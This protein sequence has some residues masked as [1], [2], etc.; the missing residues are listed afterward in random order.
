MDS[1]G[2]IRAHEDPID[3]DPIRN[4]RSVNRPHARLVRRKSTL[5]KNGIR[6]SEKKGVSETETPKHCLGYF[7]DIV[8]GGK[9]A[10]QLYSPPAQLNARNS[11]GWVPVVESIDPPG[12]YAPGHRPNLL[13]ATST[14]TLGSCTA[15]GVGTFTKFPSWEACIC[16]PLLLMLK[17]VESGVKRRISEGCK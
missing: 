10:P 2:I 17:T 14:R 13:F 1:E 6:E 12:Q 4:P 3:A 9:G 16:L 15:I 7:R 5:G 11:L 8:H